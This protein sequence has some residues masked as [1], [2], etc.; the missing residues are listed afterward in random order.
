MIKL[1]LFGETIEQ[2]T[3]ELKA[4]AELIRPVV[5]ADPLIGVNVSVGAVENASLDQ[6]RELVVRRFDAEGYEVTFSLRD[7]APAAEQGPAPETASPVAPPRRRKGGRPPLVDAETAAKTLKGGNGADPHPEPE[8]EADFEQ[9]DANARSDPQADRAFVMKTLSAF[10]KDPATKDRVTAFTT[11]MASANDGVKVSELP[12]ERF[13]L[14]RKE[15][16]AE[17]GL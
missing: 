13:P 2:F 11:R 12:I 14:V 3:A 10:F 4:L 5:N 7:P 6:L 16:E 8:P 9:P 1:E 15:M 17:F